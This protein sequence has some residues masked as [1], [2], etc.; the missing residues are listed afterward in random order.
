MSTMTR[1]DKR[2]FSDYQALCDLAKRCQRATNMNVPRFEFTCNGNIE[3]GEYP[4]TYEVTLRIKSVKA[5]SPTLEYCFEHLVT[6]YLPMDYPG[7]PPLVTWNTRIFHPNIKTLRS[8]DLAENWGVNPE[9]LAR[10]LNEKPELA[11][12][13]KDLAGYICLDA[14]KQNW[15]PSISLSKLVIELA[16]LVRYQTYNVNDPLDRRAAQ[17]AK[18]RQDQH[19]FFPLDRG[20]LEV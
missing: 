10:D 18:D 17:W 20:L 15:S 6:L 1:R 8:E 14:L 13:A 2:L 19:G 5:I 9:T 4:D 12:L 3:A 7:N 11:D 16:N